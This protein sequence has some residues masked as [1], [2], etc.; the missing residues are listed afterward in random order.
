MGAV[1][2]PSNLVTPVK[3]GVQNSLKNLDSL[4]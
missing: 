3:A 4:L 2:K 1:A